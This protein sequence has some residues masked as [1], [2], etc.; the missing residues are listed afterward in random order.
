V[1]EILNGR[2]ACA[3]TATLWIA[4]ASRRNPSPSAT[5]PSALRAR[6][7]E[8]IDPVEDQVRVYPLDQAA[9][10]GMVVL[11]ARMTEE[12]QDVWIVT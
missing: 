2:R 4:S 11:G 6:L 1:I 10:R 7:R 8:L 9:V 5:S 3:P 12:R